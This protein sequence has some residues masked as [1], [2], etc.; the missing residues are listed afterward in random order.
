MASAKI[1]G[2]KVTQMKTKE[3]QD[4]CERGGKH[5]TNAVIE[6]QKRGVSILPDP[7]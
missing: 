5:I 6:L 7:A 4:V 2:K 1:K 3:L